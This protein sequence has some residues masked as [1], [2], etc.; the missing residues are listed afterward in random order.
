MNFARLGDV[1]NFT[2]GGTPSRSVDSYFQGEIPWITG[3]DITGPVAYAARS[4]ISPEAVAKSATS[5]VTEGTVL[6]VTRTSVGKVAVAGRDIAFS[7][8]I[9]AVKPHPGVACAS[10]ITQMLRLHQPTLERQARG[11]TIKGVT[12]RDV[13]SLEIPLPPLDEQRRIAAILDKADELRTK[14]REALVHLDTLTQSLFHSQFNAD[15]DSWITVPLEEVAEVQGGLQVTRKRD[16][17]PSRAPYLRV[18][19]VYRGRLDLGVIKEIGLTPTERQRTTLQPGDLLIVE[20]HGNPEE[21]GRCGLWSGEVANC[22]HQNHLIRVRADISRV[23]PVFAMH[24]LNSLKGRQYLL[25][26]ANTTSGLNTI[27]TSTVK[28]CPMSVPPLEVQQTFAT[29][30]AAVERLKEIHL[31]HLVELDALFASLQHRAFKGEL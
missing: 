26:A 29:R 22:V 11:A 12:R 13:E 5:V 10:Y 28:T 9:T 7:Q 31:K 25:R 20:G 14:R 27:S 23:N 6:L 1:C 19:N 2:S 30:V 4:Y 24:F 21:I 17:L 3:A 16:A 18:A 15:A 8:D